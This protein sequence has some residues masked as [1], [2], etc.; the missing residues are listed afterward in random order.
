MP[1][2]AG[3]TNMIAFRWWKYASLLMSLTLAGC[4]GMGEGP[5]PVS[6]GV[7]PDN[8]E[9]DLSRI[10]QAM[11]TDCFN[12]GDDEAD[13]T[14]ETKQQRRNNLVTA[15]M[16]AADIRYNAYERNLLA[17]SRQNDLGASLA[18]QLVSAIGSASGSQA[19]SEAANI[20]NGAI[21]ATQ[22]AFSKSLLNQTVSV[23]QTHMRAQRLLQ[24][25]TNTDHLALRY[26]QWNSCQA[27]QD[28]L[29]YEQAGTLNAALA[30][31]AASATDRERAG[32]AQ[33]EA[34]I[35]TVAV[36][37]GPVV[38]ALEGYIYPADRSMW[39]ERMAVARRIVG[40]KN[41]YPDPDMN[42]GERLLEILNFTDAGREADRRALVQG[43]I[44][45]QSVAE[46]LKGPLRAI[47][48]Q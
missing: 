34:A 10:R 23:I 42:V 3:E 32:Q 20:T 41:L 46:T 2:S 35:P 31:M 37:S 19:L 38:T 45:D 9:P 33:A 5:T 8:A 17:F 44:D 30:A 39:P 40:A 27:L 12:L 11:Q 28:A 25:A 21:G 36:A 43:I 26:A 13:E 29:A 16:A 6:Q 18:T 7:A 1:I 22:S 4:A 14:D 24:R 47:L 15:Y 48:A